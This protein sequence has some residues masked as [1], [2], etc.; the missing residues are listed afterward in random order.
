[1]EWDYE[2]ERRKRAEL[3]DAFRDYLSDCNDSV[4]NKRLAESVFDVF[5]QTTP[6]AKEK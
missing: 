1:M 3:F 6:P 4:E 2:R 5:I